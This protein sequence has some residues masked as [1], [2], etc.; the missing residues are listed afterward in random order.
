[1][2]RDIRGHEQIGYTI[3]VTG[4]AWT[5][6]CYTCGNYCRPS[7]PPDRCQYCGNAINPDEVNTEAGIC[8]TCEKAGT[9]AA[10][11]CDCCDCALTHTE[12]CWDTNWGPA[13][14]RTDT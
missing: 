14:P 9:R 1:M 2:N 7:A 10:V 8:C 5:H 13:V 6:F 3:F 12:G 4:P 11:F